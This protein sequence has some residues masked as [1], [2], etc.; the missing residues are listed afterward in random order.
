MGG[1]LAGRK[2]LGRLAVMSESEIRSISVQRCD[3]ATN[4]G[5]CVA[6]QDPYCAWDVRASRCSSGD[7]TSNMAA[8]FLQSVV[9]GKQQSAL[10]LS[11]KRLSKAPQQSA[12]A[13][14]LSKAPQQSASAKRLSKAPQQSASAKRLRKAPQQ[15]IGF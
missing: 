13:K 3:R 15:I 5:D 2:S 11:V 10:A 4:C 8:S 9:S 1:G 14:R 6:L 12:S 7:W